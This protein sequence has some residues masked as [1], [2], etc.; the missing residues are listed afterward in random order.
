MENLY[1]PSGKSPNGRTIVCLCCE[2]DLPILEGI[3]DPSGIEKSIHTWLNENDYCVEK[4]QMDDKIKEFG[5][6]DHQ[7]TE[8][9]GGG[10]PMATLDTTVGMGPVSTPDSTGTNDSFYNGKVG[11][12][13]KFSSVSAGTPAAKKKSKKKKRKRIQGF[14]DFI[15]SMKTMQGK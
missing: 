3:S 15:A 7:L 10:A 2:P 14:A 6:K 9:D 8:M 12:G 11:S 5:F 13:D 4:W 1:Y